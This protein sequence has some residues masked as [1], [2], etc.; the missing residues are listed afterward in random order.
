MFSD[1]PLPYSVSYANAFSTNSEGTSGVKYLKITED[2]I[3]ED[4]KAELAKYTYE[5]ADSSLNY[6]GRYMLVSTYE[7]V[8]GKT[9]SETYSG[10]VYYFNESAVVGKYLKLGDLTLAIELGD[11]SLGFNREF[12]DGLT[13]EEKGGY[14]N[15]LTDG[16]IRLN[17]SI[18]V[19]F[20][21]VTGADIELGAL[22]DLIFGI[23]AIKT[24]LGVD[25]VNNSL[26]V[27]IIGDLGNASGP[28]FNIVLD[29]Y[30]EL[31]GE[32]SIPIKDMQ[33][34]LEVN[35][36]NYGDDAEQPTTRVLAVYFFDNA[37]YADLYG[38]LGEGMQVKLEE[39]DLLD[40]IAGAASEGAAE[41]VAT[42]MEAAENMTLHDYAYLG[43]LI[44]PGYFS[45]QLTLS[46]VQAILAKV[47]AENASIEDTLAGIEL[48]DIGDI[49]ITANGIDGPKFSLNA[50]LSDNFAASLDV[51]EFNIGNKSVVETNE[52]TSKL[53]GY[54]CIANIA[55]GKLGDFTLSASANIDLTMTS[56]GL[57]PGDDDYDD[58][59]AGWVIG[60]ITDALGATSV[61]VQPLA[62]NGATV[63][64]SDYVK[65]GGP[66]YELKGDTYEEIGTI[67]SDTQYRGS[68]NKLRNFDAGTR[69]YRT[70]IVEAV[71][72]D[73][74]VNLSIGLEADLNLGAFMLYG[75]GGLLLSDLKVSIELGYPFN[76]TLL[77][78]YLLGSS[79]LSEAAKNNIYILKSE[80]ESGKIGAYNDAAYINAEG[81]GL[82]KIK[83]QGITSLFGA[84]VGQIYDEQ[85]SAAA[86]AEATSTADGDTTDA[87][88]GGISQSVSIG[89]QISEGFLGLTIDKALIGTVF[90]LLD[91]DFELPDVQRI[92]LGLSIGDEGLSELAIG[93]T[94]DKAGTGINLALNNLDFGLERKLDVNSLV[95]EVATEFAGLTYSSTAGT[96]TLIQNI[97]DGLN[98]NLGIS[99]DSRTVSIVQATSGT[100]WDAVAVYRKASTTITGTNQYVGAEGSKY[101]DGAEVGMT[102]NDMMLVLDVIATHPEIQESNKRRASLKV[103]FGNNNLWLDDLDVGAL[104]GDVLDVSSWIFGLLNGLE[105]GGTL[106]FD[107]LLGGIPYSDLDNGSWSTSNPVATTAGDDIATTS[108]DATPPPDTHTNTTY[109]FSDMVETWEEGN[110]SSSYTRKY[111]QTI[112]L[113]GLINK[114]SVGLFTT[115]G[116]QPYMSGEY[117]GSGDATDA[118]L[119]SVKVELTKDGYNELLIYVYSM[120]L[121]LIQNAVDVDGGRNYFAVQQSSYDKDS[122]N[123]TRHGKN[124]EYQV[125]NLFRE[126]DAIEANSTLTEHQKR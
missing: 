38:L 30:I 7:R 88:G 51:K 92:S 26:A 112:G 121:G 53:A 65:Y 76:S 56:E 1:E 70:T 113:D 126:L 11:L 60:L 71:F 62:M 15:L 41:A 108:E 25:L 68:D 16:A 43:A 58:S 19:G 77:E 81:L 28:Y 120:L 66:V 54:T 59:L 97:L 110:E 114:V 4:I 37:L 21:G 99:V 96:M 102:I 35:R 14:T 3:T 45:L 94:V 39:L 116:Y 2:I 44:N 80:V 63:T 103:V 61:F 9:Y 93:A 107:K 29:A 73:N 50:K 83:F 49:Q 105:L 12:S 95:N 91:L 100:S 23:D 22:V 123:M 87:T 6:D 124:G 75:I 118:S 122:T 40:L 79:R 90:D 89:L 34:G 78:L 125:S 52:L 33:I 13:E 64:D 117:T 31:G 48:P 72:A 17:T 119:I 85:T 111:D 67:V 106:G 47:G 46:A 24:A 86:I 42:T 8:T 84:N 115:D 109:D 55:D 20:H 98:A 10:D 32:G 57:K 27:D 101:M 104:P 82:G 74:D 69:Y 36:Y 18:D 5:S